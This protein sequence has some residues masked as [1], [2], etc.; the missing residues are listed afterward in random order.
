MSVRL[1]QI[2]CTVRID[3]DL[4]IERSDLNA[5]QSMLHRE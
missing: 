2:S 1:I 3:L 4:N 5:T